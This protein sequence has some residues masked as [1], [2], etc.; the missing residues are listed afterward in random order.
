MFYNFGAMLFGNKMGIYEKKDYGLLFSSS[1]L[2]S[3]FTK[4]NTTYEF[5]SCQ[6]W[7]LENVCDKKKFISE[8]SERFSIQAYTADEKFMYYNLW[9]LQQSDI[10]EGL[11][12]VLNMAYNG[13]LTRDQ[14]IDLLQKIHYLRTYSVTLPCNVDYTKMKNGFESRKAKI[15][16]FEITEPKRRTYTEK[17]M[18]I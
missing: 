11:E 8:I 10:E 18:M 7:I 12:T 5:N 16:N 15:L 4:W 3:I 9:D 2:L 1:K 14:L 13:N 17:C 6:D